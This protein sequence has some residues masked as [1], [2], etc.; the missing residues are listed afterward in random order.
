VTPDGRALQPVTSQLI[1]DLFFT[2]DRGQ[3]GYLSPDELAWICSLHPFHFELVNSVM[4]VVDERVR[5]DAASMQ[6]VRANMNRMVESDRLAP[7]LEWPTAS[8]LDVEQ[9]R[10]GCQLR[11]DILH[12]G[13]PGT[14]WASLF[15]R[16]SPYELRAV[17]TN[18]R[19]NEA[20]IGLQNQ[21]IQRYYSIYSVARIPSRLLP[22][23]LDVIQCGW[24]CW[25]DHL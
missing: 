2:L 8:F 18:R 23:Y 10:L 19:S 5:G 12:R 9:R 17:A 6:R 11:R 3:K 1:A 21:L 4:R 14:K 7:P 16:R 15:P 24:R 22:S 25:L 13:F 20:A